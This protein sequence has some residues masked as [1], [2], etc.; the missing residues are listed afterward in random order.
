[1][2][3]TDPGVANVTRPIIVYGKINNGQWVTS[4]V[5]YNG[6]GNWN[7]QSSRGSN[8]SFWSNNWQDVAFL[9]N[10]FAQALKDGSSISIA[11]RYNLPT[12]SVQLPL[13]LTTRVSTKVVNFVSKVGKPIA[14]AAPWVAGG[15][16]VYNIINNHQITAGDVYQG[17][18]TGLSI[19][20]G[21]G[22]LIG[23]TALIAEGISYYTTG[24]SI[25]DNINQSMNG[26]V[27]RQW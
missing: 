8:G 3:G 23:G 19:I 17:I 24:Q 7:G 1:Y 4:S 6:N 20:P 21:W 11:N 18:V 25:S 15:A 14:K 2:G 9:T 22:L 26:G 12:T 5:N 10:D 13:G 27:I 16:I